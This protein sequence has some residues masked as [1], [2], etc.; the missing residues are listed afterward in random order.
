MTTPPQ[1]PMADVGEMYLVHKMLRREFSSLPDLIRGAD[2]NHARRR[3]LIGA[4]AQLA[5]QSG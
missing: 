2:R 3:A 5:E 4:H 1:V